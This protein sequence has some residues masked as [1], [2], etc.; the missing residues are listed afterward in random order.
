V[1]PDRGR[2]HLD[3]HRFAG[4][5]VGRSD[6]ARR[7]LVAAWANAAPFGQAPNELS[8][9]IDNLFPQLEGR[10]VRERTISVRDARMISTVRE[11]GPRPLERTSLEEWRQRSRETVRSREG[12]SR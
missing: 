4:A 7:H 6:V 2:N 5:L 8:R 1:A 3:E 10:G 11:I 9:S 12:R